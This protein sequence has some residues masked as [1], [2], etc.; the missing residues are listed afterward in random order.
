MLIFNAVWKKKICL[1]LIYMLVQKKFRLRSKFFDRVQY[2]LNVVKYFWPC[3]NMQPPPSNLVHVV[4]EWPL[5]QIFD[6]W[7]L[8][9]QRRNKCN[10]GKRANCLR[11]Y[12]QHVTITYIWSNCIK[13]SPQ[14]LMYKWISDITLLQYTQ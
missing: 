4:I 3:S 2:F 11:K 8:L 9:W 7:K 12:Q 6:H 10:L 14:R 13:E 1:C 5:R